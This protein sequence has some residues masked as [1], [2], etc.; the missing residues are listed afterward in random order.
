MAREKPKHEKRDRFNLIGNCEKIKLLI[1]ASGLPGDLSLSLSLSP[2][3]SR[4]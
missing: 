1:T 3:R 2:S 4:P